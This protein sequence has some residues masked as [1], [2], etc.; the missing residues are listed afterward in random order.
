[1]TTGGNDPYQGQGQGGDPQWPGY[2]PAQGGY[3]NQGGYPQQGGYD[4]GGYQQ[5]GG[6]PQ[7][8]Y[9]QPNQ[10]NYGQPGAGDPYAAAGYPPPAYQGSGNDAYGN[11]GFGGGAQLSVGDAI[12]YGWKRFS[13]NPVPWLLVI[14]A[15][16][17]VSIIIQWISSQAGTGLFTV[18]LFNLVSTV[19]GAIFG[20]AFV[21]G[22][23]HELDGNRPG[24]EAYFQFPNVVNIV[25]A[26]VL[27]SVITGIGF[28][29]LIIPGI[30]AAFLLMFTQMFV[31]DRN[32]APVAALN[33]SFRATSA[34][35]GPL[36]L[37]FI[38]L[39]G[40]NIVGAILLGIGLLV[41]VPVSVIALTYAYRVTVG[42]RV[43]PVA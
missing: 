29:L 14:V 36:V 34:N 4:Q 43:A 8:G 3:P 20:A 23:L 24:I 42:G 17:V 9:Q 25:L 31:I 1:M 26:S 16:A 33:S 19:V 12:G 7:P 35:V 37:L 39:I 27:V 2:P 28:I 6:Y 11:Q 21:R 15:F 13:S 40:L 41:T 38:A 18:L 32:E 10:Q 22:A 5:Q 30:I